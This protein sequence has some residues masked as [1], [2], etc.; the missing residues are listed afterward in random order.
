MNAVL[1]SLL[2]A[3]VASGVAATLGPLVSHY[4]QQ[5]L[6]RERLDLTCREL[7]AGWVRPGEPAWQDP[8]EG[9]CGPGPMRLRYGVEITNRGKAASVLRDLGWSV[10]DAFGEGFYYGALGTGPGITLERVD[11]RPVGKPV[12]PGKELETLKIEPGE[13]AR[14]RY[15]DHFVVFDVLGEERGPEGP[16]PRPM[17]GYRGERTYCESGEDPPNLP[18]KLR[19][20]AASLKARVSGQ[21][22]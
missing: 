21:E 6:D 4:L 8:G 10:R 16:A 13:H 17:F 19:I 5:R 2:I 7:H 20:V 9:S 18:T 1:T 22:P 15:E 14:L 12:G 11:D 3:V